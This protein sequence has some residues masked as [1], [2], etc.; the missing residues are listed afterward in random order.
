[1][2]QKILS[3]ICTSL[4]AGWM[5]GAAATSLQSLNTY[6]ANLNSAAEFRDGFGRFAGIRLPDGQAGSFSWS[7]S[8]PL[9]HVPGNPI[10]IGLTWHSFEA[11]CTASL[12]P[13]FISVARPGST[14]IQGQFATSGLEPLD[15]EETLVAGAALTSEV[16]YYLIV[17]PD[18]VSQIQPLDQVS[19]GLYRGGTSSI[20]TCAADIYI[21]G[22]W[23][24]IL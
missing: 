8:V 21:Q 4:L 18:G 1:M 12:P 11:S 7:F 9:D 16:K 13:N 20:D 14:H 24:Y 19:F 17:S 3:L 5:Q 10:V 15:G 2:K 22:A 6:G 23:I